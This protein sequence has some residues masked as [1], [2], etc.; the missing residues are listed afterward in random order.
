MSSGRSLHGLWCLQMTPWCIVSL[1]ITTWEGQL[2]FRQGQR[3]C[4]M[5]RGWPERGFCNCS[6]GGH[7]DDP[8][9][10]SPMG[11]A[12]RRKL[13]H[14]SNSSGEG[15]TN[16]WTN[17]FN[18]NPPN[19]CWAP[20]PK[21]YNVL[22][23]KRSR[24]FLDKSLLFILWGRLMCKFQKSVQ[25]VVTVRPNVVDHPTATQ[26]TTTLKMNLLEIK[27][28]FGGKMLHNSKIFHSYTYCVSSYHPQ[29]SDKL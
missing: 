1:K 11:A 9:R 12:E 25:Y 27:L 26:R 19:I 17:Y 16:G 10:Q 24:H 4:Q 3:G 6:E 7:A 20:S 8:L 2:R 23:L 29:F 14:P 21:L 5:K 15:G 13:L 22:L 28:W 18:N